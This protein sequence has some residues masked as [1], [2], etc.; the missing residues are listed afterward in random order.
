LSLIQRLSHLDSLTPVTAG[1]LIGKLFQDAG[2]PDGVVNVVVGRGSVIGD[3]FIDNPIPKLISF[4]GSTEVSLHM[5]ESA[6]RNLKEVALELGGNNVMIVL[7]DANIER[8]AKSATFGKFLNQEQICMALNRIIIE[9]E[10]R[11]EFV[12]AFMDEVKKLRVGD[13]DNICRSAY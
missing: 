10:V 11:D 6:G 1:L 7:K 8:A 9:K 13:P 12:M 5:G 2:F 3:D 4:T